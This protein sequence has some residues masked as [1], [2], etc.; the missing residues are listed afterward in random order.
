MSTGEG[1]WNTLGS[2]EKALPPPHSL[3]P[4]TSK[5]CQS[6]P[7][8][9][10]A[11]L[12]TY[13]C[14]TH[15]SCL[16]GLICCNPESSPSLVYLPAPLFPEHSRDIQPS[17][18]RCAPPRWLMVGPKQVQFKNSCSTCSCSIISLLWNES[19]FHSSDCYQKKKKR[20]SVTVIYIPFSLHSRNEAKA[21]ALLNMEPIITFSA[22]QRKHLH[23]G[24]K[25]TYILGKATSN[26]VDLHFFLNS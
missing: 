6:G 9:G 20:K 13:L 26:S 15:C 8:L 23:H 14:T 1:W 24:K 16:H 3:P 22:T 11:A 25:P 10:L 21:K 7:R 4:L 18:C 2:R 12:L 19:C 17:Q 5:R